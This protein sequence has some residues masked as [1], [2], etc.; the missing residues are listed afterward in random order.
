[1]IFTLKTKTLEVRI[2]DHPLGLTSLT[3]QNQK[4]MTAAKQAAEQGQISFP[5]PNRFQHDCFSYCDLRYQVDRQTNLFTKIKN[6]KVRQ[7]N[8]RCLVFSSKHNFFSQSYPF[9]FN[10]KV[11]FKVQ[12]NQ[13]L[14]KAVIKNKTKTP[15]L[16]GFGWQ[17]YLALNPSTAQLTL[18]KKNKMFKLPQHGLWSNKVAQQLIKSF[19]IR[20]Y[21]FANQPWFVVKNYP[22][23]PVLFAD[24]HKVI[25]FYS[26][27]T[28][29][30]FF[31]RETCKQHPRI[32]VM[33]KNKLPDDH[34][35]PRSELQT[36]NLT[37]LPPNKKQQ[38]NL[39]VTIIIKNKKKER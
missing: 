28:G 36:K 19:K 31:T 39:D 25:R 13:L 35:D 27:Q 8:A 24:D 14:I 26:P 29:Y 34:N 17:A 7:P 15:M 20:N 1:M 4:I 16:F 18:S 22:E 21:D 33:W 30:C 32:K 10:F 2:K 3:C 6:W 5:F 11:K 9:V 23:H 37:F 12:K 38:F